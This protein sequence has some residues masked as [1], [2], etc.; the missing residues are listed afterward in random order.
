MSSKHGIAGRLR[1]GLMALALALTATAG[2]HADALDQLDKGPAVGAALPHPL[3]LADQSGKPRDFAT[4]TG[5][6]GL[7]VLFSRSFEW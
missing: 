5:Q 4:L 6:R 7:I 2:A 1:A 3:T